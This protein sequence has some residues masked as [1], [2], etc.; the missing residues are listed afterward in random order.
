MQNTT[1]TA[2]NFVVQLGSLITLY[3]S[4]SAVLIVIF[5]T[6]S[7]M[8]PDALNGTWEYQSAQQSV[9]IGI[10]MLVVFFP[11]Y[12]ILTRFV[13]TI[14]RDEK[15]TQLTLTKW[16]IYLSLLIGSLIL[17]G[18]LVTLVLTYLNG[19]ITL[20]FI[21]KASAVLIVI[22]GALYYYLCDAKGYWVTHESQSKIYAGVTTLLV[23]VVL[24]LG[25][26]HSDTP[27]EVR[28]K[29]ADDIQTQNIQDIQ[30]RIEDHYRINKSLPVDIA[31][32]YV[33]IPV[34]SAP[35]G[36]EAYSYQRLDEDTYKLCA[37]YLYPSQITKGVD[38]AEPAST[39]P[40]TL[41]NPYNNWDHGTGET[42]FERSISPDIKTQ[43]EPLPL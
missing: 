37:T 23:G 3:T 22:G 41:T 26:T 32:L 21:L 24:V 33:G 15:T 4:L 28:E 2:R 31:V 40:D 17:L 30:W 27:K 34:P 42:C 18:D 10:A 25:F 11:A 38:V 5:G 1:N 16:L 43:I 20:R 29:A 12:I 6:I 39:K 9:R 7:L 8:Y 13:N 35:E 19:E 36:R 14:K